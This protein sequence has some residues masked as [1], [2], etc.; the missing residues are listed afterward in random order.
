MA[1]ANQAEED[2]AVDEELFLE[3]VDEEGDASDEAGDSGCV[4]TEEPAVDVDESL[5]DVDNLQDLNLDDLSLDDPF[6][7]ETP[8]GDS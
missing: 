8:G 3:D 1:S 5:F 7:L 6:I 2:V 4:V